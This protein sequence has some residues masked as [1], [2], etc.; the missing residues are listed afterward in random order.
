MGEASASVRRYARC[1]NRFRSGVVGRDFEK[2]FKTVLTTRVGDDNSYSKLRRDLQKLVHQLRYKG[3]KVEYIFC[4][5]I[6]AAGMFHLDGV[7]YVPVGSVDK[8]VVQVLWANIH[9]AIEVQFN[10]VR[11]LGDCTKYIVSHMEKDFD[12]LLDN[13]FSGRVLISRG[14]LPEGALRVHKLL[15]RRALDRF[16]EV[17]PNVWKLKDF[18]YERWLNY[19]EILVRDEENFPIKLKRKSE[20]NNNGK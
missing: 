8:S 13:G 15:V 3:V 11:N 17:G 18:Y 7:M 19:E 14:W 20:E 6:T 2:F 9:G 16:H 10:N 12:A 1:C 5:H 4:P